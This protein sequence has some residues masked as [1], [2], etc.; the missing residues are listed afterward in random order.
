[1]RLLWPQLCFCVFQIDMFDLCT[2]VPLLQQ[3]HKNSDFFVMT[4]SFSSKHYYHRQ[5]IF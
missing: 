3:D 2:H 5:G 1:M 4:S